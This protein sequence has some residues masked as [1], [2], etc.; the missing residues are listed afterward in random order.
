MPLDERDG[1]LQEAAG[2]FGHA[3]VD[4][5][6]RRKRQIRRGESEFGNVDSGRL[7]FFVSRSLLRVRVPPRPLALPTMSGRETREQ[8]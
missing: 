8:S 2:K 4:A 7:E 1:G 5:A 6:D 3:V